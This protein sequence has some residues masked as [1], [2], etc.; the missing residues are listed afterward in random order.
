MGLGRLV[1]SALL[2]MKRLTA[3]ADPTTTRPQP[4]DPMTDAP[5]LTRTYTAAQLEA[6]EL[7]HPSST[8]AYIDEEY[9]AGHRWYEVQ[10]V[11]FR[12]PTDGTTWSLLRADPA[13]EM[14]ENDWWCRYT[15][16]DAIVCKRV[17]AREVAVTKWF[18]ATAADLA[19]GE[20]R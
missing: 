3:L 6:W 20:A 4:E 8:G 18:D 2:I 7:P 1:R 14:Q 11:I 12:D 9:D 10:R 17:V 13:T 16:A 5:E 19:E 15:G